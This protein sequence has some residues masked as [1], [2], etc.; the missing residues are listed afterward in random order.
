AKVVYGA[1][2]VLIAYQ[3]LSD[4]TGTLKT[5]YTIEK[6]W[7]EKGTHWFKVK[8]PMQTRPA[9]EIDKLTEGGNKYEG[10]CCWDKYPETLDTRSP[11]CFSAVRYRE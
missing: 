7:T 11:S 10:V 9:Y 6:S 1:D 8:F 5:A 4:H 3:H 2:G